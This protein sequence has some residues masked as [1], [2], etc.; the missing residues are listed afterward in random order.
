MPHL[1]MGHVFVFR[2]LIST[3]DAI[4]RSPKQS[5]EPALIKFQFHDGCNQTWAEGE[6]ES[7]FEVF[8]FHDGCN[9]TLPTF[10]IIS[11]FSPHKTDQKVCNSL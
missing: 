3:M 4:K 9:Q 7:E 10:P 2:H 6:T 1:V 11:M 5:N 8:Q